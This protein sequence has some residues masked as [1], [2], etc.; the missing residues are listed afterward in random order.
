MPPIE[1][2]VRRPVT[3]RIGLRTWA[4]LLVTAAILPQLIFGWLALDWMARQ[5]VASFEQRQTD[6]VRVLANTVDGE[7]RA[8]KA[9]LTALANSQALQHERWAEFYE[10][11]KT[12]A[13]QHDGWIVLTDPTGQQRINTLRPYGALLPMTGTAA[14]LQAVL[15]RGEPL[16]GDLVFGQVA[17]RWITFV[18]VPVVQ[19]GRAIYMLDMAFTPDRL[20][21]LLERQ[22]LPA[23][24]NVTIHDSQY[25]TVTR[26]PLAE[27]RI[28]KPAQPYYQAALQAGDHGSAIGPLADG[29]MGRSTFNRLS[30]APWFVTLGIPLAAF[31]SPHP[32]YGFL[33]LGAVLAA[34]ALAGAVYASRKL[35]RP[36]GALAAN[37]ARLLQ[38]QPTTSIPPSGIRDIEHLRV[39]LLTAADGLQAMQRAAVAEERARASAQLAETLHTLNATL[40]QRVQ[41]RTADL[42]RLTGELAVVES[43][44]R[45]RLG[46]LLHDGLQ[47]YLVAARMR[48]QLL[49]RTSAAHGLGDLDQLL[50]DALAASRSL[51]AELNPPILSAEG[52]MPAL[53]W[54]ATW[55]QE[56]HRLTVH[57]NGDD[58]VSVPGD[59][60][61]VLLFRLI[62][63]LLFNV[64]KHANVTEA[65]VTVRQG[66]TSV[67]I[68][69]QDRGNGFDPAQAHR[70][71]TGG[72]GL[73]SIRQR[74]E[75]LGGQLEVASAPGQGSRFTLTVPVRPAT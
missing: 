41:E 69:V 57:V 53:H 24:W 38:G 13:A 9:V 27:V 51:T 20:T 3:S 16:V 71:A 26:T 11:A 42:Q 25:R 68:I 10:E 21:R 72:V 56:T 58:C 23:N 49:Q 64:V 12:V 33:A 34:L 29:R 48:L 55:M 7:L 39:A 46:E 36:V 31:P 47:Q 43:R 52:F 35:T 1:D 18:A 14:E 54:L 17:Q 2:A 45:R 19:D 59:A 6:T 15:T 40:E 63:E 70:T 67:H 75:Y 50:A 62:R 44:E 28:G 74:L 8:W 65:E 4:V 66:D 37:A 22:R 61:K 73:T 32:V 5:H 60:M 30:E